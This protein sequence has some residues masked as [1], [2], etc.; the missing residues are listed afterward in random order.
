MSQFGT[1]Y[2]LQWNTVPS[3]LRAGVTVPAQVIIVNIFDT[4]HIIEDS[5]TPNVISLQADANPL[6]IKVINNDED[7]FSPIRAKQATIQFKS[8]LNQFQDATTF[9]DSSDN[10]W[11]VEITA[12]G[13]MIFTGYLMLTDSQQDHLPDPNTVVL[14]A[15]DHLALL[16]DIDLILDDGSNPMGKYTIGTYLALALKRTGLNLPIR[17]VNNLRAGSGAIDLEATF[18]AA[19]DRIALTAG[20]SQFFYRGQSITIS[21]T[22]S[23]NIPI[24]V[25]DVTETDFGTSQAVL[26]NEGPVTATFTDVTSQGHFYNFI[27][28]DVKTFE[29]AIGVSENCYSVLEK[30]LGEDCFLTQWLGAWWIM[31]IDEYDN[32]NPI[33]PATFDSNGGFVSFDTPTNFDKPI[34]AAETRRLANADALRRYD[35]PHKF[36]KETFDLIPPVETICNI[37]YDRGDES[38]DP[39]K[40]RTGYTAYDLDGWEVKRKWGSGEEVPNFKSSIQRSFNLFGDEETRFIMLTKPASFTGAFEYI[41]SCAVPMSYLDQF[42]FT[43]DVSALQATSGD[44]QIFLGM[45][46]LY[47]NDGTVW[48]LQNANLAQAWDT[49][50]G[51]IDTQWKLSNE[52]VTLFRD[53]LEWS[54]FDDADHP[55]KTEWQQCIMKGAPLPVD[56]EVRFLL[57]AANQFTGDFDSFDIKYQ[58][59]ELEY[60]A[61]IGGSYRKYIKHYHKVTRDPVGYFNANRDR[62]VYIADSP[63]PLFKGAMFFYNGVAFVLTLKW[64]TANT[65]ALGPP[66]DQTYTHPYGYIQAFAVWNQYRNAN[67]IFSSSVLGLGSMWVEPLDKISLTDNNPNTNN[68]YF[69]LI[70]FE[71]NWKTCLW[72]G[73]FVEDYRT[74][75]GHVYDDTHEAKYL[76][77]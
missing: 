38:A 66:I 40:Q 43:F 12:D 61:Y 16:K 36:V 74:D 46:I 53:G 34:G 51:E 60:H 70:S 41:R 52:A 22:V 7:K 75:L 30:I 17:V 72:S 73:V 23:N 14:T 42:K 39:D 37:D 27:Y 26:T 8:A 35:R 69:L 31:R 54:I 71:Q 49:T 32:F 20:T 47:G 3:V 24:I 11:K 59:I 50:L 76:T 9:A 67:R 62:T 44:G 1:I 55:A 63:K 2:R 25:T 19:D 56:G 13:T 28:L 57:F 15:S 45:I 10:R 65:T 4:E 64:Y 21:G 58:N 77:R 33:Y 68:R 29:S 6:V 48:T 18:T 5:E